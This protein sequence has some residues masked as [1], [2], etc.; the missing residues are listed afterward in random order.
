MLRGP[1]RAI[2]KRSARTCLLEPPGFAI[3]TVAWAAMS[4]APLK[5]RD[6]DAW[7]GTIVVETRGIPESARPSP[8]IGII[9]G[10]GLCGSVQVVETVLEG[11]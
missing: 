5:Q 2:T 7:A 6:G 4:R 9:V 3:R 8:A 1:T 11:L 10:L